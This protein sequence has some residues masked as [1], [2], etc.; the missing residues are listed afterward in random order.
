MTV[1][2]THRARQQAIFLP[3]GHLPRSPWQ[4]TQL[5]GGVFKLCDSSGGL[6]QEERKWGGGVKL[7]RELGWGALCYANTVCLNL[8]RPARR[9]REGRMKGEMKKEE[10]KKG[11]EGRKKR[12]EGRKERKRKERDRKKKGREREKRESIA[13]RQV[14]RKE[15][16]REGRRME[17]KERKKEKREGR[18]ERR[19]GELCGQAGR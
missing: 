11:R 18:I 10:E 4:R 13:G 5:R 6:W 19:E 3:G 17:R 7:S 16:G 1:G 2:I 15:G 9:K 12:K 8:G 14:R